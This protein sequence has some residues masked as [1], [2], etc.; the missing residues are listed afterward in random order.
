MRLFERAGPPKR[1]VVQRETSHYRAYDDYH[2]IVTPMIV[3]WFSRFMAS[4]PITV[5]ENT[6]LD[7]DVVYL[8]APAAKAE[9]VARQ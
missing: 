2:A 6:G 7:T 8:S 4:G 3:D 1:L 5:R 9:A